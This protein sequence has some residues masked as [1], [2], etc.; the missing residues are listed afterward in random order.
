[1]KKMLTLFVLATAMIWF[2]PA[3]ARAETPENGTSKL[4]SSK[5]E[6]ASAQV[7]GRYVRL[8]GRRYYVRYRTFRGRRYVRVVGM[9]RA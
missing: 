5:T 4:L 7:R 2:A 9:R 3:M 1:M 6:I 8:R